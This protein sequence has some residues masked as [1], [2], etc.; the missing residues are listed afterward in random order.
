MKCTRIYET[1]TLYLF[2]KI[3][4]FQQNFKLMILWNS[5]QDSNKVKPPKYPVLFTVKT[6]FRTKILNVAIESTEIHT[7]KR[8]EKSNAKKTEKFF[9]N[10][11]SEFSSSIC[12]MPDATTT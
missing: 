12:S 7:S 11:F 5:I 6:Y 1:L 10:D 9:L 3:N 4:D 2:I 8:Q